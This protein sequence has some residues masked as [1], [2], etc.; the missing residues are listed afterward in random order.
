MA[1]DLKLRLLLILVMPE[2]GSLRI[3]RSKPFTC[4]ICNK[5]F[6]S[7]NTLDAHKQREH[8]MSITSPAGV[9]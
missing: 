5:T 2:S 1:N 7:K 6:E 8:S 9:G 4:L 3:G